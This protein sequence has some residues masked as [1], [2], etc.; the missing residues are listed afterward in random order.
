[1]D[2]GPVTSVT[3]LPVGDSLQLHGLDAAVEVVYD[4][5]GMPHIYG[6]TL[7][8]VFMVQGYLMSRDRFAQMEMIRR[9]VIGRLGEVLA[10]AQPSV[11][12]Q[13]QDALQEGFRRWGEMMW[14]RIQTSTDPVDVR[15]R[16]LTQAFVDGINVY[17]DN[18]MAGTENPAPDAANTFNIVLLSPAFG[19][20]R[21]E[22]IMA[23]ARFQ[24][25]S[26]SYD[27]GSDVSRT[28]T[29]AAVRMAFGGASDPRRGIFADLFA[30]YP[31]RPDTVRDGFPNEPTDTGARALL[32]PGF[33]TQPTGIAMQL[34]PPS[35]LAAARAFFDRMD[36]RF[37]DLGYG[38]EHRGSNNW[39]VSGSLTASGHPILAN[40]P[41]LSLISPPVWWYAHLNTAQMHGEE[42]LDVEGVCFAGL[43]G[44]VLGFNRHI[45][46][47]ATTTY[48]SVTS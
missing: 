38:D 25:A 31:A 7:H 27:A 21:P 11:L 30:D 37:F 28:Q 14:A 32:P 17:I 8:D 45:A 42:N 29:L 48:T 2:A 19:H 12:R 13:D 5:R 47:G 36:Q 41:H 4:D 33:G 46:W 6:T 16:L 3:Q 1:M 10:A 43:P 26:L 9:N 34:P 23:M 20:W 18:A 22:D 39:I 24:A 35:Q 15:T 40:D 44:V